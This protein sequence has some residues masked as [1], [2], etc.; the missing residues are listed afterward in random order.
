LRKIRSSNGILIGQLV[1]FIAAQAINVKLAD[2]L[3]K[4]LGAAKV[5]APN[6]TSW[7]LFASEVL[8]LLF[9]FGHS[10]GAP[11]AP[12]PSITLRSVMTPPARS[13]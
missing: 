7:G 3:S 8:D 9:L 6:R 5:L 10:F 12:P 1:Q 2:H 11:G 4:A 13:P